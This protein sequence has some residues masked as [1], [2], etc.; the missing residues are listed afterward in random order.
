[1]RLPNWIAATPEAVL[2]HRRHLEVFAGMALEK[3]DWKTLGQLCSQLVRVEAAAEAIAK[4]RAEG[5]N[6]TMP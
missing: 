4:T 5:H 2:E 6:G 3:G 1:M